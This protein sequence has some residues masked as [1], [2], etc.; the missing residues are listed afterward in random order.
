MI[1][2][3]LISG[4]A[5]IASPSATTARRQ[6]ERGVAQRLDEDPA[7][8]DQDDCPEAR[9]ARRADNQLDAVA[10]VRGALDEQPL[11]RQTLVHVERRC[12]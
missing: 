5:A 6:R 1:S 2:S 7:E 10:D 8:A 9:V 4:W 11:G 12:P 3:S